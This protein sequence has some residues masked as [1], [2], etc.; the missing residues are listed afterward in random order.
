VTV[1]E[2]ARLISPVVWNQPYK[3]GEGP[4]THARGPYWHEE[5]LR[6]ADQYDRLAEA[7]RIVAVEL[8]KRESARC[9]VVV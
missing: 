1:D 6:R 9:G 2:A 3:P 5:L 8:A 4:L 7:A